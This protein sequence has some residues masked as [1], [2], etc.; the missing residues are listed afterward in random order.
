MDLAGEQRGTADAV[1][2]HHEIDALVK[3]WHI[4]KT[5][6]DA[7]RDRGKHFPHA[8]RL[9]WRSGERLVVVALQDITELLRL[10]RTPRYG[11]QFLA[12]SAPAPLSSIKLLIGSLQMNLGR[13][14]E[15]DRKLLAKLAGEAD[16]LHRVTQ[17]LIDLSMIESGR[18]IMRLAPIRAGVD[19]A[20]SKLWRHNS[21]KSARASAH[22]MPSDLW[23]WQIAIKF[24]GAD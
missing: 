8:W 16:S 23:I 9:F 20:P 21:I 15:R 6:W 11:R 17:E 5:V 4:A 19:R 13:N 10:A 3:R 24:G 7:D 14:P 2:R 22:D 18:A 1:T 12:R